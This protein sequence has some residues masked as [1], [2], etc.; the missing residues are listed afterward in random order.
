[1][2]QAYTI[3]IEKSL[4]DELKSKIPVSNDYVCTV[5][6]KLLI[7]SY[8]DHYFNEL[9]VFITLNSQDFSMAKFESLLVDRKGISNSTLP[10]VLMLRDV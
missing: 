5:P 3:I 10:L 1:M 8:R 9:R 2:F 7:L 4:D 6:F